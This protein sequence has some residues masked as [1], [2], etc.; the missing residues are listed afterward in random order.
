MAGVSLRNFAYFSCRSRQ[1]KVEDVETEGNVF[2]VIIYTRYQ[3]GIIN[4]DGL[5]AVQPLLCC[6]RVSGFIYSRVY[7]SVKAVC[8][9]R[10][11]V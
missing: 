5:K 2:R 9:A 6:V 4:T 7:A 3:V 1:S 11:L 8:C 10:L